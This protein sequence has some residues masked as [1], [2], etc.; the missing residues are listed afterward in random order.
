MAETDSSAPRPIGRSDGDRVFRAAARHSRFV[1]F[2][3]RAIPV[4]IVTVGT[5]IVVAAFF[6]P[7]RLIAAFPIDPGKL[8]LSGTKIVMELPRL[9]GFTNNSRPYEVTARAAAQ[10]VAKPDLLELKEISGHLDMSDGQRV[11]LTAIDGLYDTK[12]ELLKLNDHIQLNSTTGYEARLS[13]ATVN[14]STGYVVSESPVDVKLINGTLTANRLEIIHNGELVRF[15]GGVELVLNNPNADKPA[16]AK[17][18][19][20]KPVA[21]RIV[22]SERVAAAPTSRTAKPGLQASA[23]LAPNLQTSGRHGLAIP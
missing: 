5:V 18:N 10:D 7:F 21:D 6:N 8:S 9:H 17:P 2:L 4:A 20:S 16:A 14:M 22:S 13:E 23:S 12:G 19:T 1:R 11:A 3:R 15:D